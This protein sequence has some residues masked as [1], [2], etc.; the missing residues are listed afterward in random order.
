MYLNKLFRA[1]NIFNCLKFP[2]RHFASQSDNN[3]ISIYFRRAKLIDSI[4]LALRSSETSSSFTSLL[5]DP[6]LDSFV[7]SNAL[8]SA[9]SITSV[10][11]FV[12]SLKS[13]PQF[14]HTQHT[15]YVLAKVLAK[16][17]QTAKLKALINGINSGK[18]PKVAPISYMD[19]LRWYSTAGDFDSFLA[20]WDEM[21]YS[22]KQPSLEAYNIVMRIYAQRGMNCEAVEILHMMIG[23]G[24]VPNSRTYTVMI[25]QLISNGKL[26]LAMNIFSL[27]PEMHVNRTLLQYSLLIGAFTSANQ[28]DTVKSLLS[29]MQMDGMVPSVSIRESLHQMQEAG[30]FMETANFV[31]EMLPDDRIKNISLLEDD[32]DDDNEVMLKPWLDPAAL[33]NAL[34]YWGPEEVSKLEDAK[35]IWTSRLVCKMI[36]NLHPIETAWKFFCWVSQ[37]PGFSHN[38]CTISKMV[39]IL[40]RHGHTDLVSE[41]LSKVKSEGIKLPFGQVRTIINYYSVSRNGEAALKVFHDVNKLC[42]P[43]P[44][45]YL[46]LL[47]STLLLTLAKSKMTS[48]ALDVLDD[49]ILSGIIPKIETFSG[50]MHCFA[51]QGDIRAVQRIFSMAKQSG[52]EPD[53]YMLKLLI[54]F[55]CKSNRAILAFRVFEE[56][57]NDDNLMMPDFATKQLLVKSL[58]K[59]SKF[60]EAAFVEDKTQGMNNDPSLVSRSSLFKTKFLHLKTVYDIYSSAF[61]RTNSEDAE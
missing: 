3:K 43:V 16:F 35:V 10:T 44:K 17:K 34:R 40:A 30:F 49:M 15:L 24:V 8:V 20:T 9:P 61:M 12:E 39:T 29:N 26:E 46:S 31:Q 28:F 7:V 36:R 50:L 37:Q 4:R 27:L 52:V 33:A 38:S 14:S 45:N 53:A 60:R 19:L 48:D 54:S 21:R 1:R 5:N 25:E 59:E 23:E 47:Y 51:H 18:F 55:Y 42:G 32:D 11:S 57:R 13:I 6:S 56:M 22:R 41:L 58:W 2:V